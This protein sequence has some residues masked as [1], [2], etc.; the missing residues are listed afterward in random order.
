MRTTFLIIVSLVTL[1][2]IGQTE[3]TESISLTNQDTIVI[4]TGERIKLATESNKFKGK[5]DSIKHEIIYIESQGIPI[6]DVVYI[7][8]TS[9]NNRRKGSRLLSTSV[10]AFGAGAIL[11][12]IFDFQD[13]GAIGILLV[14]SSPLPLILSIRHLK[15]KKYEINEGYNI[16]IIEQ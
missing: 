7:K 11:I 2:L 16:T 4:K 6:N 3:Q 10:L 12:N 13:L 1:N 5:I 14:L 9:Q 8:Y 15:K